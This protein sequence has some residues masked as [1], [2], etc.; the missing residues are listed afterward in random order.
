MGLYDMF[1]KEFIQLKA[2]E[3]PNMSHYTVRSHVPYEDGIY[4]APD[5]I[6]VIKNGIFKCNLKLNQIY[7]KWGNQVDLSTT[8]RRRNPV[9]QVTKEMEQKYKKSGIKKRSRKPK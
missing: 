6:V 2:R 3:N 7:D 4:L 9:Y 1:G 8:L 5:G